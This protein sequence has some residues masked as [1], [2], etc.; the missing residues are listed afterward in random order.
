MRVEGAAARRGWLKEMGLHV[1]LTLVLLRIHVHEHIDLNP[2]ETE[3][4]L[5]FLV[6]VLRN[7]PQTAY[8]SLTITTESFFLT[9]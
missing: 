8:Y 6:V 1:M 9:L 7:I 2:E 5:D 3:R 4:S